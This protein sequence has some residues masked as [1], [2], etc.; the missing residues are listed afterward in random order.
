MAALVTAVPI[1]IP[2]VPA[3]SAGSVVRPSSQGPSGRKS[4]ESG[5]TAGVVTAQHL[6]V[7][8]VLEEVR[9]RPRLT[10]GNPE[11]RP[12]AG[13]VRRG[14]FHG[15]LAST[16]LAEADLDQLLYEPLGERLVNRE[17]GLLAS[18]P[19]HKML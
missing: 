12:R 8:V 4:G 5:L 11:A 6:D 9:E 7:E 1:Q 19:N 13:S 14:P 16:N 10:G 15:L 18:L 2:D 3:A 17:I